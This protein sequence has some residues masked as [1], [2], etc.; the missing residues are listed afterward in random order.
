M[1][2]RILLKVKMVLQDDCMHLILSQ[3]IGIT[4]N[5]AFADLKQTI[6]SLHY[7]CV[8]F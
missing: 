7:F 2:N 6:S 4:A 8:E 3:W 1:I 5:E